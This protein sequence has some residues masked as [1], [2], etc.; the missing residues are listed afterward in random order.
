MIDATAPQTLTIEAYA[1][2]NTLPAAAALNRRFIAYERHWSREHRE[3]IGSEHH[4]EYMHD[5]DQ[6]AATLEGAARI[7]HEEQAAVR[8]RIAERLTLRVPAEIPA[9]ENV[10]IPQAVERGDYTL[11][12]C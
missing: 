11:M 10:N 12:A 3:A 8:G 7:W 9:A 1:Q 2:A 4:L 5:L 6:F